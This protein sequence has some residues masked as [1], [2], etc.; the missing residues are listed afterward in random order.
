[1]S[2]R[3]ASMYGAY[4]NCICKLCMNECQNGIRVWSVSELY[5]R[6]TLNEFQDGIRIWSLSE[7]Y[8]KIESE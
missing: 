6:D 7:L 8:L 4:L 3:M 2:I 5:L 1:M